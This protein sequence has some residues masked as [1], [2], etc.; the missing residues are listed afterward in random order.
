MAHASHL[1][2][3]LSIINIPIINTSPPFL[4]VPSFHP[5]NAIFTISFFIFRYRLRIEKEN[6]W[7][8][9]S[10]KNAKANK[11]S[12]PK[13]TSLYQ[14]LL[15][16]SR[17]SLRQKRTA[18][19]A[20]RPTGTSA[21]ALL[22]VGLQQRAHQHREAVREG[23]GRGGEV[24]PEGTHAGAGRQEGDEG[25]GAAAA[26]EGIP[27]ARVQSGG[28][29]PKPALLEQPAIQQEAGLPDD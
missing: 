20:C 8:D 15:P 21:D 26:A 29:D 4:Q 17:I 9:C 22:R 19:F 13:S 10:N 28:V 25:R 24:L 3:C 6:I 27:T 11:Y 7:T 23:N 5:R 1:C 16:L 14:V 12:E 2:S 18:I